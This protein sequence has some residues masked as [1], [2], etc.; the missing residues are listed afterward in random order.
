VGVIFVA[1]N[2]SAHFFVDSIII[3][4]V[5]NQVYL[6]LLIS[7]YNHLTSIRRHGGYLQRGM[8]EQRNSF[9]PFAVSVMKL[10]KDKEI[11]YLFDLWHIFE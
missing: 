3:S 4:V 6:F 5:M 10:M 2:Q 8:R 9:D 11:P 7:G 1:K